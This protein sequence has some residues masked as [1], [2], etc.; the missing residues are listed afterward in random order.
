[1]QQPELK[2][3]ILVLS[4]SILRVSELAQVTIADLVLPSGEIKTEIPLRTALCKRRKPRTIWL[5][6][7]SRQ[8]IQEWL[9][10]RKFKKWGVIFVVNHTQ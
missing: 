3:S 1:M 8:I 4:F 9:T 7:Q 2:R 10:Y 5:S 6:K